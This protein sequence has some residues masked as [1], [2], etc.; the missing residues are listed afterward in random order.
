MRQD[1]PLHFDDEY[2]I[3]RNGKSLKWWTFAGLIVNQTVVQYL[4]P[5][6]ESPLRADNLWIK[7]PPET[8]MEQLE[9]AT[10]EVISDD[11]LPDWEF[12]Q[13]AADLL[14]FGDLLPNHLLNELILARITDV[15]R[16][17][18]LL[19]SFKRIF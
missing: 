6:F 10:A 16:A 8:T 19:G 12:Q 14:K 13:P 2:V 3:I 1:F 5:Y 17:R 4:Q 7:L 18:E 15:P 9:Y 11:D